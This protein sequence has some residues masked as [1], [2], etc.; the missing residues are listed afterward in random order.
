M[1]GVAPPLARVFGFAPAFRS[2]LMLEAE[3]PPSTAQRS[4]VEPFPS[5]AFPSQPPDASVSRI[6]ERSSLFSGL[7]QPIAAM[8]MGW[9]SLFACAFGDIPIARKRRTAS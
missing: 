1:S 2:A 3:Q 7:P 6:F 4:D 8:I 5:A 9:L